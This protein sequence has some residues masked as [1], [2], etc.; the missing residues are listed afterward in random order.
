[1]TTER[2]FE[3]VLRNWLAQGPEVLSRDALDAA[4]T[5]VHS[6]RQVSR[7]GA[8]WR[9]LRENRFAGVTAAV[10]LLSGDGPL[11]AALALFIVLQAML[12][13]GVLS[14]LVPGIWGT[15]GRR[16][17]DRPRQF[18]LFLAAVTSAAVATTNGSPS[19][20][21]RHLKKLPIKFI[22]FYKT[23]FLLHTM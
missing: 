4:L 20:L 23:E 21:R 10:V 17:M 6:T 7:P 8:V 13:V 16:P 19:Q 15:G 12:A 18:G 2:D 14:R 9:T 1:M 22:T 11:A 3:R 5:E